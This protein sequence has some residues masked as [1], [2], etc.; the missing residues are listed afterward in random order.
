MA[1]AREQRYVIKE[2]AH[3][4]TEVAGEWIRPV[5]NA[6][7]ACKDLLLS[8]PCNK[9]IEDIPTMLFL[10]FIPAYLYSIFMAL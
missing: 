9:L 8:L 6:T 5:A 7:Q 1:F 2:C 4:P 10:T 3:S